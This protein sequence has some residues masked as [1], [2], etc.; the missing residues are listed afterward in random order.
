MLIAYTLGARLPCGRYYSPAAAPVN[1]DYNASGR[2]LL[3]CSQHVCHFCTLFLACQFL[4][5][6]NLLLY[7]VMILSFTLLTTIIC[8]PKCRG[9]SRQFRPNVSSQVSW[10]Q[11][12]ACLSSVYLSSPVTHVLWLNCTSYRVS[13][14]Y[15]IGQ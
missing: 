5:V 10:A 15:W 12:V 4:G 8:R 14:Y 2:C 7:G 9:L 11:C 13:G 1:A 3:K 6:M